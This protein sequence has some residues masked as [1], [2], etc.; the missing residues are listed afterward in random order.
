[1]DRTGARDKSPEAKLD[2]KGED[3]E[4]LEELGSG[5]G[6]T[7][8]RVLYKPTETVMA[9]KQKQIM[10]ELKILHDCSS[11]FIVGYFGSFLLDSD[12]SI[13]MEYMDYGSLENM[14]SKVGALPEDI[15]ARITYAVLSGL[16]YLYDTFRIIHRDVK[17]SN[18]L[19]NSRGEVKIADFGVSGQLIN[20]MANTFVGTSSYMSPER[21]TGSK[22]A[23]QSDVWS[24]G[25]TM[26]EV[27]I[28]RHPFPGS[29]LSILELLQFVVNEPAPTLPPGQFTPEFE[30]FIAKCLQKDPEKRPTPAELLK[31]PWVQ[32]VAGTQGNVSDWLGTLAH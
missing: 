6:G 12:I 3:L 17:P 29:T 10:R 15:V 9:R 14:L 7:V 2:V 8:N 28:G 25:I 24:L 20:S 16:V 23:V 13:V 30:D 31:H 19:L 11:P 4:M 26:L 22:Y 18:I 32:K 5:N 27:A 21:I 1:M